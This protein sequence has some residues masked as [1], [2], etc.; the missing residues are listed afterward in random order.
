MA[1]VHPQADLDEAFE[2]I[3]A[4]ILPCLTILLESLI[5][6]AGGLAGD[7][8]AIAAELGTLGA[9]LECLTRAVE[10]TA[11]RQPEPMPAQVAA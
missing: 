3:E 6:V 8:R 11:H 1:D 4:T 10:R 9:E 2:R 5:D 7:P